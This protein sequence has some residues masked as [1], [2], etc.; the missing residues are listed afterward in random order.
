MRHRWLPASAGSVALLLALAFALRGCGLSDDELTVIVISLD[1]TR[2]DHLS[3]YDY[4]RPTSPNLARLAR[5]GTRFDACHSAT[6]WTLPSHMSLFTGLPPGLHEVVIDFNVLDRSRRTMGEIFKDAGFRTMGVFSAPYVHE[7]FGFGRGFDFY[8]RATKDPMLWDLTRA[9]MKTEISMTEQR[10]HTEVTSAMVVDRGINLLRNSHASKNLLFLHFFD[11]HYDYNAPKRIAKEF[12]DPDYHGPINGSN[13][14]ERPDL[15]N[16]DMPAADLA[17][18]EG[19]YDAE[20]AWVD[21][22]IGRLLDE[23]KEEGRLDHTL[24]VVTGDHGEEFFEHGHYGHRNGLSEQTLDVP[25]IVWGPGLGVPAGRHVPDLVA[26]YDILPTLMDYASLKPEACMYGR[27]L[28]PLVQGGTLPPVP[29]SSALTFIP[30]VPEGFYILYRSIEVNG[31][32]VVTRVH[33]AWTP[34]HERDLSGGTIPG[35]EELDVYDLT[36]DPMER[37]NLAE[38]QD[39][40][41]QARVQ[42][43]LAAYQSEQERQKAA[44]GCFHPLGAPAGSDTGLSVY[45]TMKALGYFG[46]AEPT[47]G[48]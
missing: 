18:L 47:A 7:H 3:A 17:Q 1:T 6:S 43:A 31:M 4:D 45:E 12:T 16:K 13:L 19:L 10:S 24:I 28:R 39:P 46:N 11:P 34:E 33:V 23:L 8:E 5:E 15:V 25:L 42:Q 35:S 48:K 22:N 30:R 36:T 38:S 9:Q 14:T 41:V 44:L 32:K 37:T 29:A 2:P 40:A 20:L 27:S 26:N 21:E